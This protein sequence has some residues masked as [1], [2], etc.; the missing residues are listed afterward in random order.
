[1]MS[2]QA[3]SEKKDSYQEYLDAKAHYQNLATGYPSATPWT[4]S[5]PVS[6]TIHRLGD[7]TFY[8]FGDHHFS[9]D[10]SCWGV[11]NPNRKNNHLVNGQLCDSRGDCR[12]FP[13]FLKDAGLAAAHVG[14][15]V[16]FYLE[17]S[18][19]SD[20]IQLRYK[21]DLQATARHPI[22][23]HQA[24]EI[25][26]MLLLLRA[27]S[28]H[29]KA[30][31]DGGCKGLSISLSDIRPDSKTCNELLELE[32]RLKSMQK[33]SN[34]GSGPIYGSSI[35]DARYKSYKGYR[36]AL[37]KIN[38]T[39]SSA[40]SLIEKFSSAVTYY[41]V[42]INI[43][44]AEWSQ[45]AALYDS[46]TDVQRAAIDKVINNQCI[47]LE[48]VSPISTFTDM[49]K[50]IVT[51]ADE[52]TKKLADSS[53]PIK[54]GDARVVDI[55]RQ[56]APFYYATAYVTLYFSVL[57]MDMFTSIELI[58]DKQPYKMLYAGDEH[59]E[60]YRKLLGDLG[61]AK[62]TVS[63][64]MATEKIYHKSKKN[65]DDIDGQDE[66]TESRRCLPIWIPYQDIVNFNIQFPNKK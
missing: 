64:M 50:E 57:F 14:Q 25:D 46:T 42:F 20:A 51:T 23:V 18:Q 15:T 38:E 43:Y 60:T 59:T 37:V 13:T 40:K 11:S 61:A 62:I 19:R 56:L 29:C 10:G 35:K 54:D 21:K 2:V 36:G 16:R 30:R 8:L 55:V 6:F 24:G 27:E 52:L 34:H 22:A 3:N 39:R 45:S 28:A 1:M 48:K 58:T 5:G 9:W 49:L 65:I 7:T 66:I 32:Y 47:K 41:G 12:F 26:D 33:Y 31:K 53:D 4:L 44:R 17:E 63:K